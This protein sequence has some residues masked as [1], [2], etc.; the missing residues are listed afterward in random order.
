MKIS[1]LI[2]ELKYQL[3]ANGDLPIIFDFDIRGIY[4]KEFYRGIIFIRKVDK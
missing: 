2:K 4:F 3:K 1:E